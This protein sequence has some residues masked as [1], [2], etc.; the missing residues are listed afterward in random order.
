MRHVWSSWS[1]HVVIN[2]KRFYDHVTEMYDLR[3]LSTPVLITSLYFCLQADK[4]NTILKAANCKVEPFW[5]S[6]YY[7]MGLLNQNDISYDVSFIFP[8]YF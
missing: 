4:L 2:L 5:P 6:E 3:N 7:V 8:L 1:L